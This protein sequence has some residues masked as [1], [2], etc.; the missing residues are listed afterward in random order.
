MAAGDRLRRAIRG[1]TD[2]GFVGQDGAGN[3]VS[4]RELLVH[5]IEEYARNN[6]HA[7]LLRERIDGRIG[8]QTIDAGVE[9]QI[10]WQQSGCRCLTS[11]GAVQDMWGRRDSNPR[12]RD[13]ELR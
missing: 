3:P 4:L 11:P 2:R 9:S 7:D 5:M 8:Q 10:S 12:P 13:S 6:G 1:G